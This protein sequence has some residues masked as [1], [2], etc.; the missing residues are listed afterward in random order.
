[1]DC[2]TLPLIH[3][4]YCRVLSKEVSSTIFKVFGTTW[5][6]IEPRSSVPLAN[7]LP[8]GPMSRSTSYIKRSIFAIFIII[9]IILFGGHFKNQLHL[10][11]HNVRVSI[12]CH[13]LLFPLTT[14]ITYSMEILVQ[15]VRSARCYIIII[16]IK[17]I[18]KWW[19]GALN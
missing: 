13:D 3:T 4:L 16:I 10:H 14:N 2:S 5:P 17:V 19:L 1:M 18:S 7:T 11:M 6:G 15:G 8:T 9:V 12:L